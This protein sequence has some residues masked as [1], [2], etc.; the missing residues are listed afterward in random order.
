M[1][2]TEQARSERFRQQSLLALQAQAREKAEKEA[3]LQAQARE[4]AEKEALLQAHESSVQEAL[5]IKEKSI[6]F[7]KKQGS[8]KDEIAELLN[9]PLEEVEPFFDENALR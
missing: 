9:I 2:R 5:K 1:Q 3:A 4:K 6:L 8:T 7:M